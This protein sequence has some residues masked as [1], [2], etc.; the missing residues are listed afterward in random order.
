ML[1]FWLSNRGGTVW[2]AMFTSHYCQIIFWKYTQ[3][4]HCKTSSCK[5][6]DPFNLQF[7]PC[8]VKENTGQIYFGLWMLSTYKYDSDQRMFLLALR[9]IKLE[10]MYNV[11]RGDQNLKF[12][13]KYITTSCWKNIGG[14]P[15][16]KFLQWITHLAAMYVSSNNRFLTTKLSRMHAAAPGY[17]A[18]Q[19]FKWWNFG[20][21]MK[22]NGMLAAA[23]IIGIKL[24]RKFGSFN[25]FIQTITK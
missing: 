6:E 10:E 21:S 23:C 24:S 22:S 4:T 1:G 7:W 14:L 17:N 2:Y 9:K 20:P 12:L 19:K 8:L 18:Y 25:E 11:Q 13:F 15:I 5:W 16:S 3:W